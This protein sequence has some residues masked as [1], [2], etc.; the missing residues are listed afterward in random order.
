M[1]YMKRFAPLIFVFLLLASFALSVSIGSS[2][3]ALSDIW[4]AVFA[5]DGSK[6]HAIIQSIRIPRALTAAL[7]G[8]NLGAAGALM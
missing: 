4:A 2:M 7:I 8:A 1:I 3:I 5:Y 6:L